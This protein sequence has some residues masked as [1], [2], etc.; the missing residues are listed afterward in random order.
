M[1][2]A[3]LPVDVVR[4]IANLIPLRPRLLVMARVCRRWRT[5]AYASVT[6]IM[7][8]YSYTGPYQ[9]Y[10]NLTACCF[11]GSRGV[12]RSWTAE[13]CARIS[14]A[15]F[16]LKATDEATVGLSSLSSL[17]LR[18]RVPN[19][20]GLAGATRLLA[21][22]SSSLTHLGITFLYTL[23]AGLRREMLPPLP[24]LRSLDVEGSRA[25]AQLRCA[26][27]FPQLTRLCG[28]PVNDLH[29]PD[30]VPARL[31]SVRDLTLVQ[32]SSRFAAAAYASALTAL[33]A[34]HFHTCWDSGPLLPLLCAAHTRLLTLEL[35]SRSVD[36]IETP[37]DATLVPSLRNL[38]F[39]FY[40]AALVQAI[41]PLCAQIRHLEVEIFCVDAGFELIM[42]HFTDLTTLRLK[43][44][45]KGEGECEVLLRWRLPYLQELRCNTPRPMQWVT[46]VL[47]AF[48]HLTR[49]RLPEIFVVA[50]DINAFEGEVR[51]ADERGME[52]I[53]ADRPIARE[54]VKYDIKPLQR[55]L[56][57]LSL[58]VGPR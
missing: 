31:A 21:L 3:S 14:S 7:E 33:T 45:Y 46:T 43:G 39:S 53:C 5:A 37:V 32:V 2:L 24:A 6:A 54:G 52:L 40:S 44:D 13:Q 23:E 30:L 55:R 9:R 22:N 25:F 26:G 19:K 4:L 28:L 47:R 10:P 57:W 48:P 27:L 50:A 42:R 49:L 38:A 51:K 16:W 35:S 18:I 11:Q 20:V 12:P 41:T 36:L 17:V 15:S 56:R 29:E 8:P 58:S 34:L 1:A